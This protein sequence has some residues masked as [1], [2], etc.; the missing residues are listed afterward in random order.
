MK[1]SIRPLP[2]RGPDAWQARWYIGKDR[3]G[4]K[5]E[6]TRTF[7]AVNRR[8]ANALAAGILAELQQEAEQ[9]AAEVGTVAGYAKPWLKRKER[10]LSPTT[11]R[12]SYGPIIDKIIKRFGTMRL[13]E[14]RP[15]DV[16]DWHDEL[17]AQGL[18]QRTVERHHG[19][20]RAMYRDAMLTDELVSKVPTAFKRP[21]VK[22]R[23]ID[24]PDDTLIAQA[25]DAATGDF[26]NLIRL[27]S[28]T[29]MRR[30]ELLGL[31]WSDVVPGG[32]VTH[33][34]GTI[35][36]SAVL[37]VRRVVIE[38]KGGKLGTKE[39]KTG[40]GRDVVIL[41]DGIAVLDAQ[42]ESVTEQLAGLGRTVPVDGPIFAD[43]RAD[44]T[45]MTPRRPGWATQRWSRHRSRYGLDGVRIH[46][47]RH[48]HA[49]R[50][51]HRGVSVKEVADRLGHLQTSTT[52]NMYAHT[53][54]AG[55]IE[56]AR[57]AAIT[58]AV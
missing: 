8:E 31:R 35:E 40:E 25:I 9:A 57:A 20:L 58:P 37:R 38:L 21:P 50:L 45:G 16:R 1:G 54:T 22:R 23:R 12:F 10:D 5:I 32:P 39:P 42:L 26:G 43:V 55:A 46:D 49:T 13:D 2:H 53:T 33:A 30:G 11:I 41:S 28:L 52:V 18:T 7:R 29:G 14:V 4:R 51:L 47:L 36:A 3:R 27:A 56:A 48:A 15:A 34:D 6:R 44:R 24:L 19:V 17:R